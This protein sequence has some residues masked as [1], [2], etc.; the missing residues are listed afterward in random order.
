MRQTLAKLSVV[1]LIL[2]LALIPTVVKASFTPTDLTI[3][4]FKMTG[5]ESVVIEN[6]SGAGLNLQNYVLE[7]FNKSSGVNFNLPTDSQQL[8]GFIL[9]SQ[10]SF[11]LSGD[12]VATCG[13]AGESNLS[14]SLS[15]TNGYFEIVKAGGSGPAVTYTP[16][17]H[18][19]WTSSPAPA[20]PAT[21]GIDL[22]SVGSTSGV[23]N[24]TNSVYF[25][26]FSDGGWQRAAIDA[27]PCNLLV[28]ITPGG[29]TTYVDWATGAAAPATI[30]T[31]SADTG[32]PEVDI[33][34]AAPQIT[35]LLPN[36]ASPQ[37]DDEDEFIEL[38]NPNSVSFDLS[39][40]KLQVGLTTKHTYTI[41]D[42][43]LIDAGAFKAF[44]SVDTNLAMSNTSGMAALLDP[45]GNAIGQ[46]DAYGTA[47]DGQAWDLANGRWYWTTTP[48][49]GAA[50]K[51]SGVTT[52][53]SSTGKTSGSAKS[54]STQS[55]AGET[56]SANNS[57][58]ATPLHAWTLAGVGGAALL[59][60]GYE[61]R[62]DLANNIY[63]LRRY[64]ET[65]RAPRK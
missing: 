54:T 40:F 10:Q 52:A 15:D 33:G 1:L 8:P 27:T 24:S 42:G 3:I 9:Q 36:P 12:T 43:T 23:I 20:P 11:L 58:P 49:P 59:Y 4:E 17:D 2:G 39:G 25:R 28:S 37:S 41:P 55:V 53:S 30:V 38:Y 13:A 16:Q 57:L 29:G 65:R 6:T 26:Q 50:N 21:D 35:E 44:F 51:V 7:Y 22:H 56:N 14:I 60:A 46:S 48:T 19:S 47:K 32:L 62:A 31:A 63:R 5:S 61:Y 18:V 64:V 45:S 34:L